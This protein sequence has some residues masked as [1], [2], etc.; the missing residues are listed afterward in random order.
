MMPEARL[1]EA[2]SDGALA[3][4]E[5]A[6][7]GVLV[8]GAERDVVHAREALLGARSPLAREAAAGRLRVAERE[9]AR[10]RLEAERV[11]RRGNVL[12]EVL[13]L[14]AARWGARVARDA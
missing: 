12:A 11:R 4:V 13:R 5:A 10:W 3:R 6:L 8:R 14:A 7:L 2:V 1:R 9:L